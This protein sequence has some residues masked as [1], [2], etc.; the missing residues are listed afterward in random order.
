MEIAGKVALVTGGAR[1]MGRAFV[2]A[3]AERGML[4]AIHYGASRDE[5]DGVVK[6]LSSRG[7]EAV[8][9]A[10]DLRDADAACALPDRVVKQF[11]R[12]DVLVN[13]AAVMERVGVADASVQH[14]ND[15][16]NLNLRAPFFVAQHAAP[17]LA[18]SHGTIVNIA[19]LGGLEPWPQ[20]PVHSISKAGVIML[21][22]VLA[23]SLAPDVTVNAI[24]PGTVMV[25][26]DF[27]AEK[28][29]FL[30]ETTPLKRLGTPADA[31]NALLFLIE[32][33][34]FMTGETIVVDGGRVL[35]R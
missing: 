18:R 32:R 23:M 19:D 26:D 16:I 25:P 17:H 22:K 30:A 31:A 4:V 13:S 2:T 15:V 20:Y 5:A 1:R 35:R 33:G 11:G 8:S 24:A 7:H 3:L 14:W 12:L 6:E 10:A 28:R 21:T 9:F 34:D 27:D 29:R